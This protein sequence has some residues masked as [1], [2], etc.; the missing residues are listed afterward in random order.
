[1]PDRHD[2][3]TRQNGL[4][5]SRERRGPVRVLSLAGELD[6]GTADE[7]RDALDLSAEDG[8]R[9]V[10]VDLG[11]VPFC[12]SSGLNVLLRARLDAEAAGLSL[13][14]AGLR[15]PVARLFAITGATDVLVVHP[16]LGA[17]LRTDPRDDRPRTG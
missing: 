10:V 14:L 13:E 17:A 16:D 9:R 4:R 8:L 2:G 5:V 12:D 11:G 6:L 15:P 1:M 3:G 7:L